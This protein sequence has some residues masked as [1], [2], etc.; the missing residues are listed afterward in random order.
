MVSSQFNESLIRDW[1][2]YFWTEFDNNYMKKALIVNWP[3]VK[4]EYAE[5]VRAIHLTFTSNMKCRSS[6]SSIASHEIEKLDSIDNSS[7]IKKST[8]MSFHSTSIRLRNSTRDHE[9]DH[10]E[11]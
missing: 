4:E 1:I 7:L 11:L 2:K 8:T 3:E 6:T 10:D 9:R 5:L